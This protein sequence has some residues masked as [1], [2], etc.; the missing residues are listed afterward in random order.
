MRAFNRQDKIGELQNIEI[1][2]MIWE[3]IVWMV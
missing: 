1:N 2:I 3:E